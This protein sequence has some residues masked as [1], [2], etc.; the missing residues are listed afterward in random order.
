MKYIVFDMEWNQPAWSGG[1]I[2]NPVPLTGEIIEIGA[3]KLDEQLR[4]VDDFCIYVVPKYYRSMNRAVQRLTNIREKYL[5]ENG[6]PFPQACHRFL[7]WCGD[8]FSF[9]SWGQNDL[10]MLLE[11]MRLHGIPTGDLPGCIDL[12]QVFARQVLQSRQQCSLD[13]ALELVHETGEEAHDALHDARNTVKVCAH[14][15]LGRDVA[16]C[17]TLLF[18]VEPL[19]REFHHRNDILRDKKL[20][21]FYCP[22]CGE[23]VECDA[24]VKVNG[25]RSMA[26]GQ[27]SRGH[28]Y[29]LYLNFYATKAETFRT[30][31]ML[32]AMTDDL[33]QS[34]QKKLQKQLE[35][36]TRRRTR[37]SGGKKPRKEPEA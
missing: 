10:P 7:D 4:I 8:D 22:C 35:Q 6:V 31:R 29:I 3:V 24:W 18:D 32:Y 36:Q 21:T 11:N 25:G 23:T 34:Y 33:R 15:D 2:M 9:V 16:D 19:R 14:L 5:K 30:A 12:Q 26:L 37:P 20:K 28:E 17:T 13:S 27:C 1:M